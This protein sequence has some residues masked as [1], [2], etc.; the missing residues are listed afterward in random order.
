MVE[1]FR[2]FTLNTGSVQAFLERFEKEAL[3]PRQRI[4]GNFED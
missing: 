1:R 4:L 2:R 3:E